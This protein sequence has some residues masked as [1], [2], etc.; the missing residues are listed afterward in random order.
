VV[1]VGEQYWRKAFDID[2][3]L[4]E[5]VIDIEDRDLFWFAETAE[6][7]WEGLLCWYEHNGEKLI[8]EK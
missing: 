1:L 4:E 7:I 3:L 6:D 5:G 2:F 8:E